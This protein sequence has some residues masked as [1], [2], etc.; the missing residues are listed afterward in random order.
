MNLRTFVLCACLFLVSTQTSAAIISGTHYTAD[1]SLVNLSGLEWLS[2]D[3][4]DG[5]TRAQVESGYG[6]FLAEGWRYASFQETRDMFYSVFDNDQGWTNENIDGSQWL[7]DTLY[8]VNAEAAA[9]INNERYFVLFGLESECGSASQSCRALYRFTDGDGIGGGDAHTSAFFSYH[10]WD[11]SPTLVNDAYV[12][13][14]VD[15]Y[16]SVLVRAVAVPEPSVIALL[17]LGL[18]GLGFSRRWS[19]LND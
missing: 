10:D 9:T 5:L 13:I 18:F 2:W 4:T 16:S 6:G 7:Y 12:G 15:K 14:D 19:R 17:G 11:D 1:G 3:V 8:G